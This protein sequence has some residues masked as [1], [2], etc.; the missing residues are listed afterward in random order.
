[1]GVRGEASARVKVLIFSEK[2][3][4]HLQAQTDMPF[5]YLKLIAF[6]LLMSVGLA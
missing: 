5:H 6:L 4:Y 2:D 1:M 3:W